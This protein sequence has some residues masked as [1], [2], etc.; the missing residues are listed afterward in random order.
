MDFR[1][2][3]TAGTQYGCRRAGKLGRRG[4]ATETKTK[5][6]KKKSKKKETKTTHLGVV[7]GKI[8][9][10]KTF[11]TTKARRSATDGGSVIFF[12]F[13]FRPAFCRL[14][15]SDA[16]SARRSPIS[17]RNFLRISFVVMYAEFR[18]SYGGRQRQKVAFLNNNLVFID[19][20]KKN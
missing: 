20:K 14:Y 19:I 13:S 17:F 11:Q 6:K 10:Q 3:G 15:L 7:V 9:N 4:R 16:C 8:I 5:K 1:D 2:C 18:I 12:C